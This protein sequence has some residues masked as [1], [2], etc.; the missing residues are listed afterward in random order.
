MS[1]YNA[2]VKEMMFLLDQVI[3]MDRLPQVENG[4]VDRDLAQTVLDEAAKFA[5]GVL[6]PLN[7]TG[8][9]Q[10]SKLN[11][12]GTVSTPD[13]FKDAYAQFVENGWNGVVFSP[14]Y[15][16]Q[17]LPWLIAFPVQEMCHGANMSFSL[18]PMLTQ[19]AVEAI[20]N[21]GSEEQKSA[22]LEKLVSGEWTGSMQ[23][24][25]PQAGT[26]LAALKTKAE[27]QADG[28]YKLSGQKIFI[29]Y[30]EHD[31]TENTIHM[32][33]ARVPGAPEG[34]KGIS[35]FIVPKFMLDEN[36][37]PD[38]SRRNDAKATALEHKLG[39]HASPTCVM[40]YGDEGGATGFLL[41]KENEGLKYMFTMMNNARLGVGLQ[42]VALAERAFQHALAYAQDR[43]QSTK[44]G[45]SSGKRV[46]IIEHEDVRRMLLSMKTRIEA[47]RAMAYEAALAIDL[48]H[49]GDEAAQRR[50]D[51]LTPIVKSWCTDM[52]VDVASL[53]IQVHGG[54]GFIEETGAAQFYRDARILPIYEGTNGI[55]ANDLAFRKT[56]LSGG[57]LAQEWFDGAENSLKDVAAVSEGLSD[58]CAALSGAVSAMRDVTKWFVEAGAADA[59]VA[60]AVAKPYLQAFGTIVGGLMMAR[61][62]AA[63]EKGLAQGADHAFFE[64]KRAL[65]DFY[66]S[67]ILPEAAAC[68]ETV[69][70]GGPAVNR[71]TA[72]M[73]AS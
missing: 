24:T 28:T 12:D 17:G 35:M 5:S 64:A 27:K 7:E 4:E 43:V 62:A 57:V 23:L 37:G 13:G 3:G 53:G 31:F 60:A 36:G 30:G 15:G 70:K 11:T 47:G 59:D 56:V 21:H 8:D 19:A 55:Q 50:V 45:D 14:D 68:I 72:A 2:P 22:Y 73:F 63:A 39:I 61:I 34:V 9:K 10:G 29:T 48:A 46:A 33:L 58:M 16:G 69:Y 71:Y 65:A 1:E 42:G 41:G 25:E 66:M 38:H 49:G 32:I 44:I 26:D 40:Q 54:M 6:A 20:S 18:C 51:L 52:A 67:H